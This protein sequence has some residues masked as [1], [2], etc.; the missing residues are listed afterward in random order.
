[1]LHK[2]TPSLTK[3][4][5]EA[6]RDAE[7]SFGGQESG[8]FCTE[9]AASAICQTRI[10]FRPTAQI[11]D[12]APLAPE[13]TQLRPPFPLCST[14]GLCCRFAWVGAAGVVAECRDLPLIVALP[15]SVAF[16]RVLSHHAAFFRKPSDSYGPPNI[17]GLMSVQSL[18]CTKGARCFG[19]VVARTASPPSE[20]T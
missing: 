16:S 10:E 4:P 3:G 6:L 14:T 8:W 11:P 20:R 18:A 1:L 5:P 12:R 2:V 15:R 7:A 19:F 9:I 17:A 13:K